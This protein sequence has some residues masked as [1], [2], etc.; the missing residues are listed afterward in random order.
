MD[1]R[2]R[3]SALPRRNLIIIGL[4]FVAVGSPLLVI[5]L[6]WDNRHRVLAALLGVGWW[7]LAAMFFYFYYRSRNW[8][9]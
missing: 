1:E 9:K 6:T 5:A 7:G 2:D 4:V 3:M 8:G